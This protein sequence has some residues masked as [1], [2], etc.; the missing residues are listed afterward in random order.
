M[1]LL[2]EGR[3]V[4][5]LDFDEIKFFGSVASTGHRFTGV[6]TSDKSTWIA[7]NLVTAD[8]LTGL[9]NDPSVPAVIHFI[10]PVEGSTVYL[11]TQRALNVLE[12]YFEPKVTSGHLV[13]EFTTNLSE[14]LVNKFRIDFHDGVVTGTTVITGFI[15][16][17][18][19]HNKYSSPAKEVFSWE[20]SSAYHFTGT[21]DIIE[22][23]VAL[24]LNG[25]SSNVYNKS[26]VDA[27]I[28]KLHPTDPK[29]PGPSALQ[30]APNMT[31]TDPKDPGSSTL[32]LTRASEGIRVA[33]F[34]V[35]C[36]VFAS[37]SPISS[38]DPFQ[39]SLGYPE[40]LSPTD[41]ICAVKPTG[42]YE[43]FIGICTELRPDG[44]VF[45]SHGDYLFRVD[46]SAKYVI[47]SSV[48]YDGRIVCDEIPLT[49]R[50]VRS[51]V[52][53]IT[54]KIDANTVAVFKG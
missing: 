52:G 11:H 43:E 49:N 42:S 22:S 25:S 9:S 8:L 23:D 3:T 6:A 13:L 15:P 48:M 2:A 44:V 1:A 31:I 21:F 33:D 27:L 5:A 16:I 45:A 40:K 34:R 19:H 39:G 17:I 4:I 30:A 41:C 18:F 50:V 7:S 28:E 46:N 26:E 29:D 54:A 38:A 12:L 53:I 24:I 36:P 14:T 10:G 20:F 32:H 51:I 37:G 47:G 35:S